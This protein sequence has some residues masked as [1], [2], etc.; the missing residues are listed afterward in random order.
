MQM[1]QPWLEICLASQCAIAE[2]SIKEKLLSTWFRQLNQDNRKIP[3]FFPP[4]FVNLILSR[5]WVFGVY[6]K[7]L[8]GFNNVLTF[9]LG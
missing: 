8:R 3:P 6:T 9:K 2:I 7:L 5:G 1:Y 4:S